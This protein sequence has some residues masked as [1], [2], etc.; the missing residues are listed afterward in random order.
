MHQQTTTPV[1]C[2][3]ME[4]DGQAVISARELH[5]YFGVTT[6][7]EIWW[8]KLLKYGFKQYLD[9][10][11]GT[12]SAE[13]CQTY[14]DYALT[15]ECA[16]S[17]ALLQRN[18]KGQDAREDLKECLELISQFGLEVFFSEDIQYDDHEASSDRQLEQ[19][20]LRETMHVVH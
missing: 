18:E 6:T 7:F 11:L 13:G 4:L 17:I 9:F 14:V 20:I 12:V 8:K 1:R 10:N 19:D 5:Y 3:L 16:R 15:I 2:L